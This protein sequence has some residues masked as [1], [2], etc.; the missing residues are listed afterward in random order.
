MPITATVKAVRAATGLMACKIEEVAKKVTTVKRET[1]TS[2][3]PIAK[4]LW[5]IFSVLTAFIV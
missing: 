1:K 4:L 2:K 5:L 3:V